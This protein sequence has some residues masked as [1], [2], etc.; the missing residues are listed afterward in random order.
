[1]LCQSQQP[2]DCPSRLV[3]Q[4]IGIWRPPIRPCHSV[5]VPP[6]LR[7]RAGNGD[8]AGPSF[9]PSQ[10]CRLSQCSRCLARAQTWARHSTL[11]P[12]RGI[13]SQLSA[14][15]PFL[16][17]SAVLQTLPSSRAAPGLGSQ[18]HVNAH[19]Q[20]KS[21]SHSFVEQWESDASTSVHRSSSALTATFLSRSLTLDGRWLQLLCRFWPVSCQVS[22]LPEH[23]DR[24]PC[25]VLWCPQEHH[26][27][28]QRPT[29]SDNLNLSRIKVRKS[30]GSTVNSGLVVH[31]CNT[32]EDPPPEL[33]Q[34]SLMSGT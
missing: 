18:P 31:P 12:Q 33:P 13:Y 20:V 14:P 11:R 34:V 4:V 15:C 32:L 8:H 23:V 28:I 21:N 9:P 3:G 1:M 30:S 29:A 2:S 6:R 5:Q 22:N 10:K 27:R 16:L 25:D 19:R 17:A 24:R 26:T 7:P